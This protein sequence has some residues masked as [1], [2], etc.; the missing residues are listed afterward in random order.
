MTLLIFKLVLSKLGSKKKLII[1]VF[2]GIF[3]L[4]YNSLNKKNGYTEKY[5]YWIGKIQELS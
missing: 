1:I 5:V 2:T 3:I 4:Y